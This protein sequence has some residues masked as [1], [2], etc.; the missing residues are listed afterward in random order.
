M[1]E[2]GFVESDIDRVAMEASAETL[3]DL[4]TLAFK[5]EIRREA[6]VRELE[7]RRKKRSKQ[8]RLNSKT[9]ALAKELP[10]EP[11]L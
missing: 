8:M 4:E 1:E 3:A 5:H 7:R 11:S 6:T 10:D 2:H 9:R